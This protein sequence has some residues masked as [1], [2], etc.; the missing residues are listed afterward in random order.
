MTV[1]QTVSVR[2]DGTTVVKTTKL[3]PVR[4]AP[5]PCPDC[6]QIMSVVDEPMQHYACDT[7]AGCGITR[8]ICIDTGL[9]T[10]RPFDP[11]YMGDI[12]IDFD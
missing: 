1:R 5:Q 3:K 8:D 7:D 11:T 4:P 12:E 9:M 2:P 10:D 6:G